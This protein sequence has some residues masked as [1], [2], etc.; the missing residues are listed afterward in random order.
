M[1]KILSIL[2]SFA[3]LTSIMLV[4]IPMKIDAPMATPKYESPGV[5]TPNRDA[6]VASAIRRGLLPT[7]PTQ[8]QV[9]S[10]LNAYFIQKRVRPEDPRPDRAE[11]IGA[12]D[13]GQNIGVDPEIDP[14]GTDPM[15]V[16]IV[17][18]TAQEPDSPFYGPEHNNIPEPGPYDNTM[19]WIEDFTPTHYENMMFDQ[20]PGELSMA[21]YYLEQSYGMFTI[22]GDV[23]GWIQIPHSEWWYGADD[24][25]GGHD[26]FNGRVSRIVE[27]AVYYAN[28]QFPG[29]PWADYDQTG[30]YGVPDG[31]I[32]HLAIIHSGEDQ[33]A[34][35]G[36]QG[37]DAIWSH[38]WW[39]E[40]PYEAA[41]GVYAYYY[42]IMPENGNIGVFSH[43][44]G[45][46]LGLPD[47]Y[48]TIYSGESSPAFWDLMST[49][50]WLGDADTLDTRPS[51]ISVWGKYVLGWVYP[52]LGGNMLVY[53]LSSLHNGIDV[54]MDQVEVDG[55]IKA[56]QVNLPSQVV[57]VPYSGQYDWWGNQGN[58]IDTKLT[59]T[60]DLTG[61]STATLTFWTWYVIEDYWDFGFVQVS[62]DDGA[63]WTS[64]YDV[65]GRVTTTHD[66]EAMP[67]IVANLP[68]FT[69]SSGGWVHETF[70]LTPYVGEVID[71]RFRYMTD[72]ATYLLG[73]Y[74]D[75]ITITADGTT[76][77]FDDVETLDPGWTAE[78]W[79]RRGAV[80]T[81]HY[82]MMEWRNFVGFDQSLQYCYSW[83]STYYYNLGYAERFSYN[84]GLL[85]WY[86]NV[87]YSD[88]WVGVHPGR[89]YLLVVDSHPAPLKTPVGGYTWR[90]SVQVQDATFSRQRTVSN[91]LT[92]RTPLIG[93]GTRT[94]PSLHGE[95]I[96]DDSH[97]Y[98]NPAVEPVFVTNG[99]IIW[100]YPFL[101]DAGTIV[102]TYGLRITVISQD[103]GN[104]WGNIRLLM[105]K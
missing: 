58:L 103:A 71:L 99:I 69:A 78:Y 30:P 76:I 9:V 67:E 101:P 56:V 6:L 28:I 33:A 59:R 21:N 60:V 51:H 35:G 64:L 29:I 73:W 86:R 94:Y 8:E 24:P 98:Y 81:A 4:A 54:R 63:T 70:D 16:L 96:F 95:P 12:R 104:T 40:E 5:Y 50:S 34:G 20:T 55:G 25:A 23:I 45:H 102:P 32:D 79:I 53:S 105:Q 31:I 3:L 92:Y 7:D 42:T 80:I 100:R 87:A 37:D 27:D 90:T 93:Y 84:P 89:G 17:E 57:Q 49:G 66:P 13:V 46:D 65:E 68:G 47:S 62:T 10:Y 44:F 2:I 83:P 97:G 74:V 52:G 88:N 77:F 36:A 48:D 22:E 61:K 85:L 75:D 82:Y 72:W 26:N 15:I 39:T 38:S 19:F 14:I 43:E 41:P 11:R 18:F 1:K 91:T